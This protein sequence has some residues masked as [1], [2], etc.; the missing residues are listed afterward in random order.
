MGNEALIERAKNVDVVELLGAYSELRRKA[1]GEYEGPCPFCGG[2]GKNDN[3]FTVKHDGWFCR[4]CQPLD[5]RHGW[6]S[7]IDFVQ[8]KNNVDFLGAVELLTGDK[9]EA[10]VKPLTASKRAAATVAPYWD[11]SR[12]RASLLAAQGNLDASDTAQEYLIGRGLDL[13]TWVAYGV[14]FDPAVSLPATNGQQKAPALAIPWYRGDKLIAIRY[15]FLEKHTYANADGREVSAKQTSRGSFRGALYG[16]QMMPPFVAMPV[17]DE[18]GRCAEQLRTLVLCE[19]E[20]NTMSIW[21]VAHSWRWDV[22]SVGSE[23]AKLSDGAISV[24]KRYG[25]V[26]VWMDR[27]E[28]GE[29]IVGDIGDSG[30]AWVHSPTIGGK[31]CDA[32]DLLQRNALAAYL[33]G[34][35]RRACRSDAERQRVEYDF[36]G[37]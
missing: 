24:A 13:A 6:H 9:L 4:R 37:V 21:Q 26:L 30:A 16:G 34:A 25:R 28:V 19:G 29:R 15:R 1:S 14:G 31:E 22:L 10:P 11:E 17:D 18:R 36:A 27:S 8:R 23:S 33:Q 12:Y 5:P 20:I 2:D 35:R 32:N 3:R 7:A